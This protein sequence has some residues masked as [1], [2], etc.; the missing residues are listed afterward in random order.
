MY[1][2]ST[3]LQLGISSIKVIRTGL[4]PSKGIGFPVSGRSR[5]QAAL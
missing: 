4:N 5:H 2:N 1:V 3:L